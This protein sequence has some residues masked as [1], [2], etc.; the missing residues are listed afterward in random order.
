MIQ[1]VLLIFSLFF[2]P[3]AWA[4]G[5]DLPANTWVKLRTDPAGARPGSAMRYAPGAGFFLWGFMND[6]PDLLQ[7][8]PLMETPEYDMV[9]FDLEQGEWRNHF[10][11]EWESRWSR[12]L[13]LAYIPATYSGKTSG[14]ERIVLR[15]PSD[16][17]LG[18][19][20]FM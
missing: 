11:K 16:R 8:L 13:P 5:K 20:S 12:K 2:A 7:E 1:T 4:A 9:A 3:A 18:R 19:G 10:P 17:L 15:G 6:N 14:S